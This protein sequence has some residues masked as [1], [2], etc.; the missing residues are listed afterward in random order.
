MDRDPRT[1]PG[2]APL[3]ASW[4]GFVLAAA[5]AV[6]ALWFLEQII[7]AILLL[8]FAMVMAIALSAPVGW[9]IR[10]GLSRRSARMLTLLLFFGAIGLLA[11]VVIPRLAGQIAVL[12]N[13]LPG[14]VN[15][16]DG[17][18]AALLERF[19]DLHQYFHGGSASRA[20]APSPT[21]LFRGLGGFSLSLLGVLA[22]TIIFFSTV[23]YIVLNPRPLLN[24]YL[25]SLPRHYLP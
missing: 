7:V 3:F 6:V 25:G 23:A 21:E 15:Q 2:R 17:Q 14:F 5:A 19:P 11:A 20:I 10:R 4:L 8:F 13:Q 22:L 12:A 9:F 16:I 24:A 1:R 18:I